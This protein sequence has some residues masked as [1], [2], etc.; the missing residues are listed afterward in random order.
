MTAMSGAAAGASAGASFGPWGA[1]IGA[2]AGAVMGGRAEQKK[3]EELAKAIQFQ[4]QQMIKQM[5]QVQGDIWRQ[6]GM[7]ITNT[8]NAINYIKYT[9]GQQTADISVQNAMGDAVGASAQHAYAD[10]E[11]KKQQAMAQT[12]RGM[13]YEFENTTQALYSALNKN[14]VATQDMLAY[15]KSQDTRKQEDMEGILGLAQTGG[16]MWAKGEFKSQGTADSGGV[17]N[18][19]RYA[20]Q[21][22]TARANGVGTYGGYGSGR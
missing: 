5:S 11:T 15:Y 12:M 14:A 20:E 3:Q 8:E 17:R 18:N 10:A 22:A 21:L 2:V 1:A 6:T 19:S 9:T 16:S 13:E 4:S 7:Q